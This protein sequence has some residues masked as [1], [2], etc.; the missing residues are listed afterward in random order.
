MHFKQA[1]LQQLTPEYLEKLPLERVV[2]LC[3]LLRQDLI[4][5]RDALNQ[6]PSNSS[7]PSSTRPPWERDKEKEKELSEEIAQTN[8]AQEQKEAAIESPQS[9]NSGD[10]PDNRQNEE[11][12]PPNQEQPPPNQEQ[13][14]PN[15]GKKRKPGKQV[16]APGY[17][18]TQKLKVTETVEHKPECCSGCGRSF[19][20][21]DEFQPTGG[22][23]T[24]DIRPPSLGEV[25]LR[26]S[27]TKHIYGKVT[28]TCGYE[29]KSAPS[30]T[31]KEAGWSVEMG[32]WKLIG[33]MLLAFLVFSKLRLHLTIRKTRELLD[34]WFGISL[35]EGC[36]GTA[37]LEAG[38]AVSYLEPEM[39]AA[40]RASGLIYIDETSWKE[41]KVS[42]WLWVAVSNE[43][44]YFTVGSRSLETAQRILGDY[45]GDLMTDGY[46]AYRSFKNRLRCWPHLHRKGKALQE[47]W[48]QD[49]ATFGKYAVDTFKA[50]RKSVE[51]M[52][53]MEPEDRKAEQTANDKIRTE[54]L[55]KCLKQRDAKHEKM[56]EFAGE[57]L[58]DHTT[59]FRV[60]NEPELPLTNNTAERALRPL[61]ILRKISYG[62]KTEE[63]SRA[64]SL[65]ASVVG[66]L[67]IQQRLAWK[68][69]CRLFEARRAARAPPSLFRYGA[70]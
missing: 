16:G 5:A 67:Y 17:G 4:S 58:N 46:M 60:L 50:L 28:C 6:N 33:P 65:L 31:E 40:L 19:E 36:I 63:G 59:I 52:R 35:S 20:K 22:H 44:V 43:V 68:F 51:R 1:D 18:R 38:R 45:S 21:T 34:V 26:G 49:A 23:C 70:P 15:E 7:R 13:P 30:R 64:T 25:G 32:E 29:T 9:S 61:V 12:P 41:H 55:Y 24:I 11:Q 3:D 27:Y 47:S 14:P 48:D 66:T 62:S 42:R 69:L 53:K 8:A 10:Q 2:V 54:F 37:L 39:I 56:A 57:V